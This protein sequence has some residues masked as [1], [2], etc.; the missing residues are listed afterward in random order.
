M[1]AI[2]DRLITHNTVYEVKVYENN[3]QQFILKKTYDCKEKA[4]AC[5]DKLLV[6]NVKLTHINV[7]CDTVSFDLK[8]DV[9]KLLLE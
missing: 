9:E 2:L 5:L 4:L 6:K 1:E 3:A 7:D 8:I